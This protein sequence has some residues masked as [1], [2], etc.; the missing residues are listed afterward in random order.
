MATAARLGI[1]S[2]IIDDAMSMLTK[3]SQELENLLNSL[4]VEKQKAETLGNELMKERDE[5]IK[6]NAELDKELNRLETEQRYITRETRDRILSEA[7]ELHKEIRQATAELR[8]KKTV[9]TMRQARETLSGVRQQLDSEVWKPYKS[10]DRETE[11]ETI[12]VGDDVWIKE[13][14]LAATVLAI[15][16]ETQEV[17][18]QAGRTKMRLGID[19]VTKII[20]EPSKDTPVTGSLPSARRVPLQLDLRGKRADEIEPEVDSY[21][22]DAVR[23]NISQAR[24]IHG[25]GTG[26]VRNIVRDFLATHPLVKSLRSGERDEGGDGATI[27]SL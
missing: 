26:T 16:E 6:R 20:E 25:I 19:G 7:A 11:S 13:A 22:N 17:D 12:K 23:S 3:G 15:S 8:K 14:G 21:L 18:V 27:V 10:P 1:P 2:E 4:T 5:Y 24:I 9:E